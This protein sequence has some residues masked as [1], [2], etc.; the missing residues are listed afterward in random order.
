MTIKL[1]EGNTHDF[2]QN[3]LYEAEEKDLIL[4]CERNTYKEM[5]EEIIQMLNDEDL[6]TTNNFHRIIESK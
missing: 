1:Y 3:T 5:C 6:D 2:D 4:I